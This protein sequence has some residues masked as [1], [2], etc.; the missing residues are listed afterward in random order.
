MEQK[1]PAALIPAWGTRCPLRVRREIS[2]FSPSPSHSRGK[3]LPASRAPR[4]SP[5]GAP[6]VAPRGPAGEVP[7]RLAALRPGSSRRAGPSFGRLGSHPARATSATDC[8]DTGAPRCTYPLSCSL[9]AARDPRSDEGA[10]GGVSFPEPPG[11]PKV[12]RRRRRRPGS[13]PKALRRSRRGLADGRAGGRAGVRACREGALRADGAGPG[14]A[15]PPP[16][17]QGTRTPRDPG[18][19]GLSKRKGERKE[20]ERKTAE[21][22]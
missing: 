11:S 13:Q 17:A 2:F 9:M 22:I 20:K 5:G 12:E 3:G 18:R 8:G 15:P 1:A 19:S 14:R 10:S 6:A 21:G 7:R 16:R 4:G